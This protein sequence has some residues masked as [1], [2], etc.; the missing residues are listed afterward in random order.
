MLEGVGGGV[1]SFCCL[2]DCIESV[3][4]WMS[5]SKLMMNDDITELMAILKKYFGICTCSAQLSMLL[6][7]SALEKQFLSLI[8]IMCVILMY[9]TSCV[10]PVGPPAGRPSYIAKNFNA[11]HNTQTVQPNFF[12]P[13]M[14]I[15]TINLYHFMPLSLL[16]GHICM[17]NQ[18]LL[19]FSCKSRCKFDKIKYVTTTY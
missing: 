4:E 19:P 17:R 13:A 7:K 12:V 11:G 3:T 5:D 1:L 14:V 9:V 6:M 15:D 2:K 8:H 16:Q 18:Q 10:C